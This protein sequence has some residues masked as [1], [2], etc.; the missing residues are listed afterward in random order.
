MYDDRYVNWKFHRPYEVI[1]GISL[2]YFVVSN[3]DDS[4][5]VFETGRVLKNSHKHQTEKLLHVIR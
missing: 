5:R 4:R 1:G 3:V 2:R